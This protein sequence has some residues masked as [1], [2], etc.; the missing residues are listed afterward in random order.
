[1]CN[2]YYL[3]ESLQCFQV[4]KKK[5]VEGVTVRVCTACFSKLAVIEDGCSFTRQS[6]AAANVLKP[7]EL[8]TP[9]FLRLAYATLP[10]YRLALTMKRRA[11]WNRSWAMGAYLRGLRLWI[12]S[13]RSLK[14]EGLWSTLLP[15]LPLLYE[16]AR[17]GGAGRAQP[18][19]IIA[20]KKQI[21]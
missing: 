5:L 13:R 15:T 21:Y 3:M 16:G 11:F 18:K 6:Q 4:I 19:V 17:V 7:F 10:Y 14:M 2:W 8:R 20:P 1:M 12:S 9:A